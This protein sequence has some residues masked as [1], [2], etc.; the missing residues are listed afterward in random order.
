MHHLLT[1]T[2]FTVCAA[3]LAAGASQV[4]TQQ[5]LTV[6]VHDGVSGDPLPNAPVS[7]APVA[8]IPL[9]SQLALATTVASGVAPDTQLLPSPLASEND[10]QPS[11]A[12][13]ILVMDDHG[14]LRGGVPVLIDDPLGG[15][16]VHATGEDG[17]TTFAEV[18]PDSVL[19]LV[20]GETSTTEGILLGQASQ[21]LAVPVQIRPGASDPSLPADQV[22]T[23]VVNA[24]PLFSRWN[25]LVPSDASYDFPATVG[26]LAGQETLQAFVAYNNAAADVSQNTLGVLIRPEYAVDLGP[27]GLVIHLDCT[28]F[29]MDIAPYVDLVHLSQDGADASGSLTA[30]VISYQEEQAIVQLVGQLREGEHLVMLSRT[31]ASGSSVSYPSSPFDLSVNVF[32]D[33]GSWDADSGGSGGGS[34]TALGLPLQ[35]RIPVTNCDPAEPN[36]G[37]LADCTP[38]SPGNW[39]TNFFRDCPWKLAGT[40][41]ATKTNRIGPRRCGF[42]G[43]TSSINVSL[44]LTL[45][46]S[47]QSTVL[48]VQTTLTGSISA[49]ASMTDQFTFPAGDHNLGTCYQAFLH[50][51]VCQSNYYA[52]RHKYKLVRVPS[53]EGPWI[54]DARIDKKCASCCEWAKTNCLGQTSTSS[55]MCSRTR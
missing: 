10:A 47:F 15:A 42:P 18:A 16:R 51:R 12:Y 40:T 43:Q 54:T 8:M 7:S 32:A 39:F 49:S 6:V 3:P 2:A 4:N 46:M 23:R 14:T 25:L 35:P 1:L 22:A 41:C 45:Q 48:G 33:E 11:I 17:Q 53:G 9:L 38:S 55:A 20:L 29:G 27:T 26:T 31:F 37:N 24:A 36:P 28:G 21:P 52:K 30:Q 50:A 19:G 34:D 5:A 13:S 44:T